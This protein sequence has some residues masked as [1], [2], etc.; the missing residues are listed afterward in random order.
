MGQNR[1]RARVACRSM[2][3]F[4]AGTFT[5]RGTPLTVLDLLGLAT[6]ARPPFDGP[7]ACPRL[8]LVVPQQSPPAGGARAGTWATADSSLCTGGR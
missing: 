7:G 6:P 1:I 5:H 3:T 8:R 4:L 2:W